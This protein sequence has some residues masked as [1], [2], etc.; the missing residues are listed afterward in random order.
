MPKLELLSDEQGKLGYANYLK[1]YLADLLAAIGLDKVYE[2]ASGDYLY[3]LDDTGEEQQVLDLLGGY[4]AAL[5]GHNHPQLV[6]Q[7][8]NV[9]QGQRPFVAQ[10]SMRSYAGLLAE[11][12]AVM[13][14]ERTG[15]EF[16]VTLANTGTEA[17]EAALK[18][19]TLE[20]TLAAE[21]VFESQQ[22]TVRKIRLA[23]RRG[24]VQLKNDWLANA[25]ET[26]EATRITNFDELIYALSNYNED[27]LT[28]SPQ[29]LAVKGAFHGK[30]TGSLM[31]TYNKEFRLPWRKLGLNGRFVP[32]NDVLALE[33]AVGEAATHY[34]K[35][36]MTKDGRLEL[37]KQ[38]WSHIAGILVEPI[39]GEGGIRILSAAFLQ[40]MR[41]LADEK[42]FPLIFDEIQSGLGRTGTFLAAEH[43]GV[44]ADYYTFSKS[45]GGGLAKIG[46]MLVRRERYE[47]PF[48]MLHTSTFAEDDFSSA[49]ALKTLEL[50]DADEGS[51]MHEVAAKGDYLLDKLHQLQVAYPSVIREVRGR[52]LMV[53]VELA[54]QSEQTISP[55]LRVVSEQNLL[56]YLV[57]GYLLHEAG[58]RVTPTLSA[59][60]TIRLEPS[61]YIS[62]ADI[63]RFCTALAE[64]AGHLAAANTAQLVAFLT[65][66]ELVS[67]IGVDIQSNGRRTL[68]NALTVEPVNRQ[69]AC[70]AHFM[71]AKD[72]KHWDPSLSAL[73]DNASQT[74]LKKAGPMLEPF[75]A[76]ERIV[77]APNGERIGLTIIGIPMTSTQIN[78]AIR[79]GEAQEILDKLE[80]GMEIARQRGSSVVGFTGFTSIVSRNVTAMIADD[81]GLTSGN[82]LTAAAALV[83]AQQEAAQMGIK[84]QDMRL[85]VVGAVGNIGQVMAEV[86]A[87]F[88][89]QILLVG[90][91][92]AQRRLRRAAEKIY[93]QAWQQLVQGN[94]QEGIAGKIA[95]TTTVANIPLNSNG[96]LGAYLFDGLQE[97][98]GSAAPIQITSDLNDLRHC[99]VII[100]ATNAAQPIIRVEH[101][102]LHPTLL[103]DVAVP[104]DIDP[105]IKQERPL[106]KIVKGGLLSLPAGQDLAIGGMD[107]APGQAYACVSETLMMGM[108]GINTHFSY[109]ALEAKRVRQAQ[110]LAQDFGFTIEAQDESYVPVLARV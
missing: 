24:E 101:I 37:Q 105:Q 2:R 87:D 43:A 107:V 83:A 5:F 55:L 16:V 36:Q 25:A 71:E 103:C 66:E 69:V 22:T 90:R 108:A 65:G 78:D 64:I 44:A 54:S 50:L 33:A 6:Q 23:M 96:R 56:S 20:K 32:L 63:D 57:S 91:S 97:E 30:T 15:H 93:L 39:Q 73:S 10:A 72:L 41:R 82:S 95:Q 12:L 7:A 13:V 110:Q 104:A 60:N 92:G 47:P 42:N 80:L 99:N 19:A 88:A 17:V 14:G 26:L 85:G 3:Y 21:A 81:M 8:T 9:L 53:G 61:A 77:T 74:L 100:S 40:S 52:G 84:P 67:E 86:A 28:A 11:K 62:Y 106:A 68:N 102:G 98:L 31:L 79:N 49:I 76:A 27:V 51:L 70:M 45:L 38:P 58:I 29:F 1:P 59:H 75:I 46:A 34:F 94:N 35:L 4:G 109:G 48:G 18:H 89:P